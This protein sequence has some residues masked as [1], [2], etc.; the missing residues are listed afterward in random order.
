[1][2]GYAAFLRGVNL[3]KHRRVKSAD[4]CAACEDAGL[5]GVAAFRASGNVVFDADGGSAAELTGRV[6]AALAEALGFDVVVFLRSAKQVRAIAAQEPFDAAVAGRAKGKLQVAILAEEPGAAARR[7]ALAL[8]TDDD[9]LAI[10]GREL[11]W[12]PKGGTA[13]SDLDQKALEKEVGPWT[14]RTMGTIEQIA[15][16]FFA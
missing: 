11:Y 1:V 16:K 15:A 13:D 3:G 6:E 2:P 10:A 12:L 8:A 9:L 7:A 4:L 14:M 5:A